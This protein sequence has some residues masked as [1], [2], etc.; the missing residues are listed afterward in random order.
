MRDAPSCY[1]HNLECALLSKKEDA[2]PKCSL[3]ARRI[4]AAGQPATIGSA[5]GGGGGGGGGGA[6]L[7]VRANTQH[8]TMSNAHA[9]EL[10]PP[11]ASLPAA[12]LHPSIHSPS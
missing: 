12:G 9:P 3:P 5:R 2:G 8:C 10:V 7:N 6:E 4:R 1:L 11:A